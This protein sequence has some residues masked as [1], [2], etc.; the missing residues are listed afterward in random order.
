MSWLDKG[1][2]RARPPGNRRSV[3]SWRAYLQ[4]SATLQGESTVPVPLYQAKAEFF[5]TLGHPARIRV[6]ELLAERDRPVH[7][8]LSAIDVE[9]PNLSHQLAVLRLAGLVVQRREGGQVVYSLALPGGARPARQR[10]SHPRD[11]GGRPGWPRRRPHAGRGTGVSTARERAGTEPCCAR[12]ALSHPAS[13]RCGRAPATCARWCDH[14][15]QRRGRGRH[16]RGRG[17]A[18]G[19]RLR[20]RLGARRHGRA[21]DRRSSPGRWRPCS[22]A[23]TCRCPGRPAR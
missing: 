7:E 5:R 8:M 13:T 14:P 19:P 12:P 23:A 22:A 15:A 17:A 6:L 20:H 9:A 10:A 2:P 21:R 4:S 1:M 18:P 3:V 16:G 11:Q